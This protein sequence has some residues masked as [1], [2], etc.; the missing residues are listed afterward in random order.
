MDWDAVQQVLMM[1]A[2]AIVGYVVK[3][4]RVKFEK[5]N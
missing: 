2:S 4:L 1:F 3:H 5:K